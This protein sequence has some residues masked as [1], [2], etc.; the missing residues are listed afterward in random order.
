MHGQFLR[1]LEEKL[2][3]N[4]VISMAKIWKHQGRKRKYNNG[5]SRQSN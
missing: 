2:V 5:T 1:K 3:D 4:E